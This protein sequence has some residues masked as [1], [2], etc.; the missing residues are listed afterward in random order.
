MQRSDIPEFA[1]RIRGEPR[2]SV[3]G[4][5]FN[6]L[7]CRVLELRRGDVARPAGQDRLKLFYIDPRD[8]LPERRKEPGLENRIAVI[9][10]LLSENWA[11]SFKRHNFLIRTQSLDFLREE[12]SAAFVRS[13]DRARPGTGASGAAPLFDSRVAQ[14]FT[15]FFGILGHHGRGG[16]NNLQRVIRQNGDAARLPVGV[17]KLAPI[18]DD[19]EETDPIARDVGNRPSDHGNAADRRKSEAP[20]E[21][22]S[23]PDS[24]ASLC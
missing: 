8:P 9:A 16:E 14:H 2:D 24:E 21:K 22:A 11:A 19:G 4:G 13:R 10:D 1:G 20:D 5:R 17:L 12:Q 15:G 3:S 6:D 18:L 7:G 23:D